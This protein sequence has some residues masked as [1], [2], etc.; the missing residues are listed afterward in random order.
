MTENY[1][2]SR[3]I[4]GYAAAANTAEEIEILEEFLKEKTP[5]LGSVIADIKRS[6]ESAKINQ[7]WMSQ[8]KDHVS[9]WLKDRV[10]QPEDSGAQVSTQATFLTV[11]LGLIALSLHWNTSENLWFYTI[12]I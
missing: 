10:D 6:I 8:N 5:E 2:F 7:K 11:L 4:S 1:I 9:K 3:Q 12:F